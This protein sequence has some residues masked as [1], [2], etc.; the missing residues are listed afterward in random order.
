[1]ILQINDKV[2]SVEVSDVY[3]LGTV[4]TKLQPIA[5]QRFEK[6][7]EEKRIEAEKKAVELQKKMEAERAEQEEKLKKIAPIK[8]INTSEQEE[9]EEEDEPQKDTEMA[10]SV[11]Q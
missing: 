8:T 2:E 10:E 4:L 6:E 7:L 5:Q 11:Q 3:Q 9:V 1:M